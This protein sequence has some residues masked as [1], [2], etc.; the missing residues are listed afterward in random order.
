MVTTCS[1][2]TLILVE[3]LTEILTSGRRQGHKEVM[4]DFTC[5]LG[6]DAIVL[7]P[8]SL[9]VADAFRC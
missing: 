6:S 2:V 4:H 9:T 1:F 8:Y 3:G 5:R 7:S